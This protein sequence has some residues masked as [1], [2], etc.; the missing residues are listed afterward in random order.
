MWAGSSLRFYSPL[1]VGEEVRRES[2]VTAVT[3]KQG[4][5]GELV[6]V[7]VE[8]QVFRGEQLLLEEKQDIVYR[9]PGQVNAKVQQ[10]GIERDNQDRTGRWCQNITPDQTLL[11]RYSAL[12]FN[13]HRIH[14]DRDY[15][16][17]EEGYPGLVVQG[18]LTATLLLNLLA[19]EIPEAKLETFE[20]RGHRP[21]FAGSAIELFGEAVDGRVGLCAVN[22]SGELALSAEATLQR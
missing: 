18:P 10:P 7:E 16:V 2:R 1:R 5:S 8:H 11:F 6:F 19:R 22:D 4:H 14:Y 9:E 3:S 21:L 13:S 20:F 12:T 17:N 15:A